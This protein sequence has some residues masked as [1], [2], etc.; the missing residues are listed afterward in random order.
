MIEVAA[1]GSG[2]VAQALAEYASRAGGRAAVTE[3]TSRLVARLQKFREEADYSRGFVIDES[4]AREEIA[5]ARG[6]VERIR[7]DLEE[8]R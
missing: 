2:A 5:A 4:G 1:R 3:V 7:R 8:R 6:L